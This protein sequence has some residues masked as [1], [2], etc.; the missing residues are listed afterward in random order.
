M[1][2]SLT[3]KPHLIVV[4]AIFATGLVSTGCGD[5]PSFKETEA[6]EIASVDDDLV[7]RTGTGSTAGDSSGSG[8]GDS[9]S[10][11]GSTG[12]V[13]GGINGGGATTGGSTSGGSSSGSSSGSGSTG[14]S[15]S[16]SSA[17]G[18]SSS[19]GSS[20][21][22]T[23]GT[24]STSGDEGMAN[25]LDGV[26]RST[27][28]AQGKVDILWV[29]DASG[30]MTEE[31]QYL[32]SNFN[33][34]MN[35]LLASGIDFQTGVTNT[36]ICSSLNPALVPMS[37]RYCPILDG[38]ASG[39]LR[40]SL[41]GTSGER[42]LK[43]TTSNILAKFLSYAHVGTYGSGFEHGLKAAEMAVAKSLAG[44]NENL[45]RSDSF[46]AVIVVSDEEDDGIG[47]GQVDAFSGR[48]YVAEGLTSVRYT[49][50]H[51]I[52]YLS[53]AKGSGQF[54]VS[55]I[56]GTKLANG[57]MCSAA[58]SSPREEGSQYIRA[59]NKTGGIVQSICDTNW[60]TSLSR[61][62][63]DIAAQSAQVVL[64]HAPYQNT[65][66]VFVGGVENTQWVYASGNNSIK[67]NA[68][69]VPSTGSSIEVRYKYAP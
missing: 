64:S 53:N 59:A 54:S 9:S 69:Q 16:G 26:D 40:G 7:S 15:S 66:R 62:G 67:F 23:S 4:S 24:G 25:L 17:G 47:L 14:G 21:G 42:V 43:P 38:S 33:S 57:A 12:G 31:Q 39:R 46:L 5:S 55:T 20:S 2:R 3:N 13:N 36:D 68:G 50:D 44:Q 56:T 48:N 35:Q 63:Q 6:T 49:E 1:S 28:E 22:S 27:V 45:V 11:G 29:V 60:S 37:E 8:S 34:F 41:T 18:G 58:H 52:D 51:L 61:I 10:S 19:G 32:G 65:I 30:S